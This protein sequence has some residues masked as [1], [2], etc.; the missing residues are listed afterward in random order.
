LTNALIPATVILAPSASCSKFD[1]GG[2]CTPK[3]NNKRISKMIRPTQ[4]AQAHVQ[5]NRKTHKI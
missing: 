5:N 2:V 3:R 4:T 1:T